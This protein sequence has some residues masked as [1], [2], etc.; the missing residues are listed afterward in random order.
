M[1]YR[2]TYGGLPVVQGGAAYAAVKATQ[3]FKDNL[4]TNLAAGGDIFIRGDSIFTGTGGDTWENTVDLRLKNLIHS[5]STNDVEPGYGFY[6]VG[7]VSSAGTN[8]G[9]Y[10]HEKTFTGS[11]ASTG[12]NYS[13][14]RVA[15]SSGSPGS[16]CRFSFPATVQGRKVKRVE[17]VMR[18]ASPATATWDAYS[19]ATPLVAGDATITA[20]TATGI[21]HSGLTGQTGTINFGSWSNSAEVQLGLLPI[22]FD[23]VTHNP[24]IQVTTDSADVFVTGIILYCDDANING[25]GLRV[26][27]MSAAGNS[28]YPGRSADLVV[29]AAVW[30]TRIDPYGMGYYG[31]ANTAQPLTSVSQNAKLVISDFGINDR[32]VYTSDFASWRTY[33]RDTINKL[34]TDSAAVQFIWVIPYCPGG[35]GA[36]WRDGINDAE[37]N[38]RQ[39]MDVAYQ[40]QAEFPSRFAVVNLD[41]ALGHDTYANAIAAK[42]WGQADLVHWKG[43]GPAY[44]VGLIGSV[45][46]SPAPSLRATGL[47]G[48]LGASCVCAVRFESETIQQSRGTFTGTFARNSGAVPALFPRR[49]GFQPTGVRLAGTATYGMTSS[50]NITP[51]TTGDFTIYARVRLTADPV[52]GGAFIASVFGDESGPGGTFQIRLGTGVVGGVRKISVTGASAESTNAI[53]LGSWA[54]IA[55]TRVG[56]VGTY[57]INGVSD[58]VVTASSPTATAQPMQIGEIT[59]FGGRPMTGEISHV[60]LWNRALSGAELLTLTSNPDALFTLA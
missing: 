7:D 52:T 2:D 57:Y 48:A 11:K 37:G 4:A 31:I 34:M 32:L 49:V 10:F 3:A 28:V 22:V 45:L 30:Q 20:G 12:E 5:W 39:Y 53:A 26:H 46:P 18:G 13:V 36:G 59:G 47:D 9:Q 43:G 54:T 15:R 21:I 51:P 58:R 44:L 27:C 35:V 8:I 19:V 56:S 16:A 17:L 55:Y 29:H 33:F 14:L 23:G 25:K 1:S 40:I 50:G 60:A 38:W 24:V 6:S 41:A 42:G